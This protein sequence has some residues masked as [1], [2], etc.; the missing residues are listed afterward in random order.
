MTTSIVVE[1]DH[2]SP[3]PSRLHL[4]DFNKHM[5]QLFELILVILS[6]FNTNQNPTISNGPRSGSTTTVEVY[7]P[8][9]DYVVLLWMEFGCNCDNERGRN[10]PCIKKRC[11]TIVKDGVQKGCQSR[12]VSVV[13][14]DLISQFWR[15]LTTL[16]RDCLNSQF[17]RPLCHLK[18]FSLILFSFS[19]LNYLKI[20]LKVN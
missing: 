6:F 1:N 13:D 10:R 12:G 5:G 14:L 18:P 9:T 11:S 2:L 19:T 20:N 17:F 4:P 15:Q 7:L 3:L 8:D 16:T